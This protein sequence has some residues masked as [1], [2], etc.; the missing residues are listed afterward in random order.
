MSVNLFNYEQQYGN[1]TKPDPVMEHIHLCGDLN[2]VELDLSG[3]TT[4][5]SFYGSRA[6]V[7]FP[8][9]FHPCFDLT[10]H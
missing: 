3:A 6:S 1:T 10:V 9:A 4:T 8:L 2:G 5:S 7:S